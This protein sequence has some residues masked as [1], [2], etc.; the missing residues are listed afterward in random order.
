[1]ELRP[2][3]EPW[4]VPA[5]TMPRRVMG[6][7]RARHNVEKTKRSGTSYGATFRMD[8]PLW[9]PWLVFITGAFVICRL[10]ERRSARGMEKKL[11]ETDA[12]DRMQDHAD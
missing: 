5:G 2:R 4:K 3:F 8:F 6:S 1:M 12:A 11:A 7:F 9:F 10:M